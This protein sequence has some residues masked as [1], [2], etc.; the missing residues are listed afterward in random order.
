MSIEHEVLSFLESNKGKSI[1]GSQM[2]VELKVS[3]NAVWKAI[4]KLQEDGYSIEAGTNR[5]Y[6]LRTDNAVLS[7]QGIKKYL[8]SDYFR[9]ELFKSVTSTNTVLKQMAENGAPEGTVVIAEEQTMGK[10]RY[11]RSFYS[12]SNTGIYMS[13]LLR[14]K[15]SATHSLYITTCAAV[16]VSS[17]IESNSDKRA[18][19]K[20]V[21]DVYCDNKKV[22]GILTEAA[23][24]IESG[25]MSYAVLGIGINIFPPRQDF[26]Y[27]LK[28]AADSIFK[29]ESENEDFRG[30][31]IAD[32]LNVFMHYYPTLERKEF[33][34]EYRER[35]MLLSQPIYIIRNGYTEEAVALDIDD[36]FQLEVRLGDG[37][38]TKLSSGEVSIRKK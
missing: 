2:A 13:I 38:I 6:C 20:W 12:P 36:A 23:F 37:S 25:G 10:G 35:S 19:I 30:R 15:L 28:N 7:V 16:A 3:R 24:D 21:N 8:K 4:K 31:I 26:P 17:A 32:V 9:I 11:G 18:E 27:E 22:C 5:G 1:S 34:S 14:P 29:N 33:L